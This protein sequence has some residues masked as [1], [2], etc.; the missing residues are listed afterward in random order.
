LPT[1]IIRIATITAIFKTGHRGFVSGM[2]KKGGVMEKQDIGNGHIRIPIRV[3][4]CD[5]IISYMSI[6]DISI[7][8]NGHIGLGISEI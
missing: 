6:S 2:G 1:I 8:K 3:S 7:A 4:L 5:V